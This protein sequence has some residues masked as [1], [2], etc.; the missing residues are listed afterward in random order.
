MSTRRF[1][2]ATSFSPLRGRSHTHMACKTVAARVV[3]C[4]VVLLVRG[5]GRIGAAELPDPAAVSP[6]QLAVVDHYCEGVVFDHD[7]NGY[8]SEGTTIHKFT[9]DGKIAPWARTGAPNGH[10][11]LADGTH[12]VCDASHHAVL[13][14]SAAGE[15]LEPASRECQGKPLRGPNDLTLDGSEGGFVVGLPAVA[16]VDADGVPDYVAC[17]HLANDTYVASDRTR[18]RTGAQNALVAVSGKTGAVLWRQRIAENW[19][20]YANASS[21]AET[22]HPL[23]RPAL[24][25]VNGRAVVVLVEKSSLLG[26]D[27][28]TGEPA[29][30]PLA[31]GFA[32]DR[33]PDLADLDGDG[34]PDLAYINSQGLFRVLRGRDGAR[35][36]GRT[37]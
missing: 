17:F 4:Y 13:R 12:L 14:L 22:Y 36:V 15:M 23:C 21:A 7:G 25:R 16:D 35:A 29:W 28:R 26:F 30:P 9:L 18:H 24:A 19:S 27:A 6:V 2:P 33:A 11:I 8:L 3:M 34:G 10:K 37:E 20:Q 1:H 5:A 31:L 32:P